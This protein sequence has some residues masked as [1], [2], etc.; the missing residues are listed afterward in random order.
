MHLQD[1]HAPVTSRRT[2]ARSRLRMPQSGKLITFLRSESLYDDA[3]IVIASSHGES[4]GAHG[5]D[6]HGIFLYDETIHVPL[7]LKLP[8]NQMAGKTDWATGQESRAPSR[9]CAHPVVGSGHRRPGADA[10]PVADARSRKPA[11]RPTN[12][13]THAV[14]F[15]SRVSDAAYSSHGGR[16]II[17]TFGRRSRRLYDLSADPS[18]SRNLAQS[19]KATL[20]T[21]ALATASP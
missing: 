7:V 9:H 21:M 1:A 6:T 10:R 16:D 19:A 15:R 3:L 2:I 12:R 13:R 18:A 17:S 5:E 8:K 4:L 11:P 14:N 20:Q